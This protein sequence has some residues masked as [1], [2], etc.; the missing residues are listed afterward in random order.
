MR[1]QRG[2]TQAREVGGQA[3]EDQKQI[4]HVNKL[5]RISSV[6]VLIN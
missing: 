6:A 5:Y 2:E 4:Q 1:T 3:S